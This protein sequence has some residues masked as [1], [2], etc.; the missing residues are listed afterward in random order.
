MPAFGTG[1]TIVSATHYINNFKSFSNHWN[2]G[3][4]YT[5][6][7]LFHR[8]FVLIHNGVF[9]N[10]HSKARGKRQNIAWYWLRTGMHLQGAA[11]M[12]QFLPE[13]QL[14]SGTVT[15]PQHLHGGSYTD[16]KGAFF[17]C[18]SS[19]LPRWKLCKSI[20]IRAVTH[21]EEWKTTHLM[22]ASSQ[23]LLDGARLYLQPPP[24]QGQFVFYFCT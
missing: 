19:L 6:F 11:S 21:W 10:K 1:T 17:W 8:G 12:E 18:S 7:S 16:Y 3:I 2:D 9:E 22:Q 20:H 24:P 5:I 13:V 15:L 14:P 4:G 23:M